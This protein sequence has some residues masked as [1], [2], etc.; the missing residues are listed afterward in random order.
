MKQAN[1]RLIKIEEIQISWTHKAKS[2][3]LLIVEGCTIIVQDENAFNA[4]MRPYNAPLCKGSGLIAD[5]MPCI[6]FFINVI[7][8]T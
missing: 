3:R 6:L 5:F 7:I 4:L 2:S 1:I 8:F